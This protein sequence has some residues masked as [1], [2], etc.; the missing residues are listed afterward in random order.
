MDWN[1]IALT[2]FVKVINSQ[3]FDDLELS[4]YGP[5][6]L[7]FF[8]GERLAEANFQAQGICAKAG[9]CADGAM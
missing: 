9:S 2:D 7:D 5:I 3:I 8:D 1:R 4:C 6:N